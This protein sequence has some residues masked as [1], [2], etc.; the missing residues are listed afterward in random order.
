[1]TLDPHKGT[2]SQKRPDPS[3][4]P[5]RYLPKAGYGSAAGRAVSPKQIGTEEIASHVYA[6]TS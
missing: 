1:M 3:P 5:T 2:P 6:P 4:A